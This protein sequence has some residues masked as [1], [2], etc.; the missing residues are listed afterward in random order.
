MGGGLL[1]GLT[2]VMVVSLDYLVHFSTDKRIRR[3]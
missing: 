3:E 2:D 1:E